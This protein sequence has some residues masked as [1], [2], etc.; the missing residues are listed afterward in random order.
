VTIHITGRDTVKFYP[1]TFVRT[2]E[3]KFYVCDGVKP[4][5]VSGSLDDGKM[6]MVEQVPYFSEVLPHLN[7]Y[8][9]KLF[10]RDMKNSLLKLTKSNV[11]SSYTFEDQGEGIFSSDGVLTESPDGLRLFYIYYYRNQFICLDSNLKLIYKGKTIDTI[12][13]AQ[14]KVGTINSLHEKTLA[15]PPIF[16][17]KRSSANNEYLFVHSALIADNEIKETMKGINP[18]DIYRIKDGKYIFSIYLADFSNEKLQDF[19]VCEHTLIALYDD[20][21]YFE[22]LNF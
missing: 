12:S 5:L 4:L 18:I 19:R 22:H 14:I 13:H 20:Y 9:L 16:V 8:I 21:L 17:N 10:N 15:S 11:T 6:S 3:R 1:G 2:Y 7:Y